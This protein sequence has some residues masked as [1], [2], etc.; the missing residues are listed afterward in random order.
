MKKIMINEN[1]RG[2][3]F[4][5]G[6]YVKMLA[7]GKYR[8]FGGREIEITELDQP[9][10]SKRCTLDTLLRDEA[11]TNS[12]SVI[13]V[14][15]EELA[16]H[17]VNGKFVSVLRQGKYAFWEAA[18]R[19]EYRIS[20]ISTPEV[21]PSVPEYIFAKLPAAYYTKVEVLE[22]HRARKKEEQITKKSIH[23]KTDLAYR[24]PSPFLWRRGWDSN[25]CAVARKLISSLLVSVSTSGRF[26]SVSGRFV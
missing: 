4:K 17:F 5:N 26:V 7:A 2:F 20:D 18:G 3:L 8:L 25:P 21:D 11:V 15:D 23:N 9:I 14:A 24:I 1:Q 19:H 16:L 12:V 13:E 6:K 22:Y 10:V